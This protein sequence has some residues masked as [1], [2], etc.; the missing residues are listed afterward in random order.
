MKVIQLDAFGS[1]AVHATAGSVCQAV[2]QYRFAFAELAGVEFEGQFFPAPCSVELEVAGHPAGDPVFGQ[3]MQIDFTVQSGAVNAIPVHPPLHLG[4]QIYHAV[5][6][7]LQRHARQADIGCARVAGK[8][9]QS[10]S[11]HVEHKPDLQHVA[12]PTVGNCVEAYLQPVVIPAQA[13]FR[14]GQSQFRQAARR[15]PDSGVAEQYISGRNRL[16]PALG[17]RTAAVQSPTPPPL[18]VLRQ[19]NVQAEH[20]KLEAVAVGT[21]QV[22]ELDLQS[23]PIQIQ[24]LLAR[25]PHLQADQRDLGR[26]SW[27][28]GL[29]AF[30]ADR[31]LQCLGQ[32]PLH[33]GTKGIGIRR[34]QPTDADQ[35][36]RADDEPDSEFPAPAA[37]SPEGA[38]NPPIPD[39]AGPFAQSSTTSNCSWAYCSSD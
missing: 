1:H 37:Q 27:P 22:V 9:V 38:Q 12:R 21:K 31:P 35:Y 25:P 14:H 39:A 7:G 36:S 5:G 24:Q 20:D 11:G 6:G 17:K 28:P 32:E 13:R 23:C 18:V 34:D 19:H 4:A 30:D 10:R 33:D 26:E 2:D 16:L 8:R 15:Y 29:Y 3:R